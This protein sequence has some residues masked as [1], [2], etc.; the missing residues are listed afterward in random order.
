MVKK[1]EQ[2]NSV[3]KGPNHVGKGV[4][5]SGGRA[6]KVVNRGSLQHSGMVTPANEEYTSGN[7]DDANGAL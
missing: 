2:R 1:N 4:K 6:Q 5:T 3:R 7:F